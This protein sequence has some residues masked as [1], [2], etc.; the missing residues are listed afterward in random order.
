MIAGSN[1]PFILMLMEGSQQIIFLSIFW[2]MVGVGVIYKL[3]LLNRYPWFSLCFYLALGWLGVVT[4]Y[5]VYDQLPTDTV[6]YLLAGGVAYTIGTYYYNN[7]DIRYNHTIW[8]LFVMAGTLF[9]LVAVIVM[10]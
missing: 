6:L 3:F 8:H 7:D 1:T 5:Q 10:L 2:S 4:G 9:H